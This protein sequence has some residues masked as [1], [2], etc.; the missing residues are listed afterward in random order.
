MARRIGAIVGITGPLAL[1][2][3][4]S[5]TAYAKPSCLSRS[6]IQSP[7]T[8]YSAPL[9]RT[10][11]IAA[12][13]LT[14]RAAIDRVAAA[15]NVQLSY[16]ADL[17][18]P[19]RRV[20]LAIDHMSA[21]VVLDELLR[22]TVL[23]PLV[24][25]ANNVA[26]APARGPTVSDHTPEMLSAIGQLDRI[27][28]TGTA[29]GAKRRSS[30]FALDVVDGSALAASDV[31]TLS[32]AF[33]GAVPGL[34][35]WS[36]SPSNLLGRFG[37][38]R[39][40]SSFGVTSPKVY[41]DGIELANPL[42]FTQFD[43]DRIDRVE[44]I[45]GPQ[46]AALYGAD[47]LSGVINIITRH[48][49]VSGGRPQSLVRARAGFTTSAF[50][51]GDAFVQDHSLGFRAGSG[52]RSIGLGLTG[53]TVG[54]YIPGG[55]AKSLLADAD[56]RL[57]G[58][59]T[60][61]TG[62]ARFALKDAG[63]LTSP[64]LTPFSQATNGAPYQDTNHSTWPAHISAGSPNDGIGPP[65]AHTDSARQQRMAATYG[66]TIADSTQSL[67]QYT[68]GATGTF[69]AS[70][71]WTH[72][73]VAGIDGYRLQGLSGQGMS[74]P[75]PTDSFGR[76]AHSE[77]DR[78]TLALRS[79]ARVGDEAGISSSII[80]GAEHTATR[81]QI[82]SHD[83]IGAG[84]LSLSAKTL[85]QSLS[86]WSNS[87][88]LLSQVNT[89]IHNRLFLSV[90]GRVEYSSGAATDARLNLLPMMG[91]A[92]VSEYNGQ[93]LKLRAAYGRGI[94]PANSVA[95]AAAWLSGSSAGASGVPGSRLALASLR[96]LEPESQA[97]IEVGADVLL[98]SGFGFHVTRFDQRATGLI[99]AV[100]LPSARRVPG[101]LGDP[102]ITYE[103]QNVGAIANRGWELQ[104][105]GAVGR[106]SLQGTASFVDSR[107][108]RVAK[109]Y[110]GELQVG[111]R[112]LEVPARTLGLTAAYSASRW[113]TSWTVARAM[114]WI[115]Y[116]RLR[117]AEQQALS[118]FNPKSVTGVNLRNFWRE[119]DGS[120]RL[121]A[122]VAYSVTRGLSLVVMGDNLLNLQRGEPDNVTVIPGRTLTAGLRTRF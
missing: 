76:V 113:S 62:M 14:L 12:T 2:L 110:G 90:G 8:T 45:R 73:L 7:N 51:A 58:T 18:P 98:T 65:A 99:Q 44:V 102:G 104:A 63:A 48:D 89:N 49:G 42:V 118:S 94:R 105:T 60:V 6:T 9:D 21:G 37:S 22:G 111:D 16:S 77:A 50:A 61:L 53:G 17:L 107:V 5:T 36:Q 10:I 56:A 96:N 83:L 75:V 26:L 3:L 115:N 57:V 40:A 66:N 100:A 32:S 35:M 46:G 103:A 91:A 68:L 88:G 19:D 23:R 112:M 30:P 47:A 24:L 41:I 122:N 101:Q 15:S 1:M 38:V 70:G 71:R 31:S 27:V 54:N 121:R 43:P 80:L 74:V 55:A 79:I 64:L 28:V 11:S 116:D 59:R 92:Y 114:D 52:R 120:T 106:L 95:R 39:G 25:D 29:D 93:T 67:R 4:I 72:T 85:V 109:R 81:E 69:T 87:A 119:Y 86:F 13:D 108:D 33:D 117:I 97:G 82:E 20:C 84:A 78:T 34:W